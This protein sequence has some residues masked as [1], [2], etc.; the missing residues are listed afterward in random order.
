VRTSGIALGVDAGASARCDLDWVAGHAYVKV[1]LVGV[2]DD[3]VLE[4]VLGAERAAIAVPAGPAGLARLAG[5]VARLAPDEP[6]ATP[7]TVDVAAACGAW[8][9]DPPGDAVLDHTPWLVADGL[10]PV[11]AARHPTVAAALVA[12]LVARAEAVGLAL[13][14]G[15]PGRAT[16]RPGSLA[17]LHV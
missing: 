7:L 1:L 13:D 2:D 11:L 14:D 9:V 5:I 8:D 15:E 10:L 17:V 16:P 12:C 4:A 3:R 6:R